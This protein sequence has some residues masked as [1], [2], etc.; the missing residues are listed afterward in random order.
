VALYS[1]GQEK[2]KKK[3]EK[4]RAAEELKNRQANSKFQN[5]E[6][7]VLRIQ[8]FKREFRIRLS[9]IIG[10]ED[11]ID[12]KEQVLDFNLAASIMHEMSFLHQKV[13][14]EHEKLMEDIY[15]IF[16][17][18]KQQNILAENLQN[19]LMI[20]AGERDRENEVQNEE[21]NTKWSQAGVYNQETGLFYIRE[22]EH[23]SIQKHFK[24]LRN[25]RLSHKKPIKNFAYKTAPEQPTFKP[26]LSNKTNQISNQR[27]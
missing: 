1:L 9:Q 11:E 26:K 22:G 20:I 15:T 5:K 25:N 19:L 7:D 18:K 17:C 16:K 10:S 6:S 13:S 3:E 8:A 14:P 4:I 27:R 12:P 21:G 24:D 23:A 2:L